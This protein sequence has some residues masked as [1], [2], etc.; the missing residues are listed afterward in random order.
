MP[1]VCKVTAYLLGGHVLRFLVMPQRAADLRKGYIQSRDL[2]APLRAVSYVAPLLTI[3]PTVI[4]EG[5]YSGH[6]VDWMSTV[7]LTIEEVA[8]APENLE[9]FHYEQ[10]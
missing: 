2:A 6:V 5:N 4:M 3:T 8:A 10:P 1:N 9:G 7:A